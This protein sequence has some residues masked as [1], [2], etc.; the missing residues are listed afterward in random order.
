MNTIPKVKMLANNQFIIRTEDGNY[1]QSYDKIIAFKPFQGKV[2]LD[3]FYWDFSRTT[4]KYLR[5]FLNEPKK[6]TADKIKDGIYLLFDLNG[7]H[8]IKFL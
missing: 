4:S 6:V 1:L 7:P 2:K 8:T 3:P 5:I